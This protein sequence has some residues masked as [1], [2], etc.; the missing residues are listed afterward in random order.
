M[1]SPL[2][3]KE[4]NSD[5]DGTPKSLEQL[6]E[7]LAQLKSGTSPLKLG[8]RALAVL[9]G[10][11]TTPHQAAIYSISQLADAFKVNASTLSRLAKSLG[12]SGFSELQKVFRDYTANTGRFYSERAGD[13]CQTGQDQSAEFE[14]AARIANDETSNIATMLGNLNAE[15]LDGVV[16]LLC[17]APKIRT[18]GLRQSYPIADYLSYGL[19]MIRDNVA[20]LSIAEH[21]IIH[22]LSQ[23]SEGDLLFTVGCHPY[24][25][26]TVMASRI[27]R[28]HGLELVTITDTYSSPLAACAKHT[29]I[30]PTSGSFF[31]NSMASSLVLIEIILSLTAKKLGSSALESLKH[32]ELLVG[33]MQLEL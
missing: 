4:L 9:D 17:R 16:E 23:L 30:T 33:Q 15:S 14:L 1:D 6:S 20:V 3:G 11:V 13:L 10:M 24:T 12:Y 28:D 5:Y 27:A 26:S 32:Y 21:G 22:G 29:F 2:P 19:G 31:N 7:L 25:R 18:H 8:P